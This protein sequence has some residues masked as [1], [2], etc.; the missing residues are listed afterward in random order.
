MD[1]KC[2]PVQLLGEGSTHAPRQVHG[3]CPTGGGRCGGGGIVEAMLLFFCI[4]PFIIIDPAIA[5]STFSQEKLFASVLLAN[6]SHL[7]LSGTEGGE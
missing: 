1:E 6:V 5:R 2:V 7:V 4:Y 3:R